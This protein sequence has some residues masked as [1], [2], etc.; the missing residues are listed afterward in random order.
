MDK[1]FSNHIYKFKVPDYKTLNEKLLEQVYEKKNN[2]PQGII[3][4]NYGGWHSDAK[5]N[6]FLELE[7]IVLDLYKKEILKTD[8]DVILSSIWANINYKNNYN[9]IHRHDGSHFSGVYYAK[10]PK[11]SGNLYFINQDTS[12]TEPYN[13][14]KVGKADEVKYEPKEGDLYFFPGGLSHRVGKNLTNEDRISFSWN[15]NYRD[16]R[17]VFGEEKEIDDN[18]AKTAVDKVV[19]KTRMVGSWSPYKLKSKHKLS[20]KKND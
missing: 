5:R 16:L 19:K 6:Q 18:F 14:F 10:V 12:L 20:G 13:Y 2:S 4:S 17:E 15:F 11:D 9:K 7:E 3:R 1:L 8:K